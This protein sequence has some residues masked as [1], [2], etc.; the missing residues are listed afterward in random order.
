[1]TKQVLAIVMARQG[2]KGKNTWLL[3]ET[4][5]LRWVLEAA[6]EAGVPAIVSTDV[7]ATEDSQVPWLAKLHG[8]QWTNDPPHVTCVEDVVSNALRVLGDQ[9]QLPEVLV[10]LQ[11]TSPFIRPQ[12]IETVAAATDEITPGAQSIWEVPHALHWINQ[13][14]YDDGYGL[15]DF[16]SRWDRLHM[17][18]KQTKPKAYAF[19]GVLAFHVPTYHRQLGKTIWLT[20]A[21]A[22]VVPWWEGFD[23][24]SELDLRCANAFVMKEAQQTA[25]G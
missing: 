2:E 11:P 23:V 21:N 14:W 3:G 1:M 12:T 8:A 4:P 19:G 24:D 5:L 18:N 13:R 16:T 9:G 25:V 15:T 17:P 7:G 22:T 10:L 20:P 6:Q